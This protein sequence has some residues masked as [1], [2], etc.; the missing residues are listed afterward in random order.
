MN[1][2]YF[3]KGSGLKIKEDLAYH[4]TGGGSATSRIGNSHKESSI[5]KLFLKVIGGLFEIIALVVPSSCTNTEPTCQFK[6]V[7]KRIDP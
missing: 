6:E 1:Y 5:L 4:I 3:N 2:S 7:I